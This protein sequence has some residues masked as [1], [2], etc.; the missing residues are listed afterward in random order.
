MKYFHSQAH[1][2]IGAN[3]YAPRSKNTQCLSDD[4]ILQRDRRHVVQHR[5]AKDTPER[6]ARKRHGG[7]V[8]LN[9]PH[10]RIAKPLVQLPREDGVA[11]QGGEWL[12]S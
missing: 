7:C 5:K 6:S 11:L 9:G 12:H 10:M 8:P 2:A 1:S 4:A 3:Q